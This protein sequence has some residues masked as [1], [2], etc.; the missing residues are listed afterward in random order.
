VV[1]AA[2]PTQRDRGVKR[3]VRANGMDTDV[4]DTI[5]LERTPDGL[6]VVIS[7]WIDAPPDRVWDLFTDTTRWPEWGP[8]VTAVECETRYIEAGSTG[9]VRT[10]GGRWL[11][12]AITRFGDRQWTWRIGQVGATGHRVRPTE[13]GCRVGFEV[14]LWAAPY[15]LVCWVALGRIESLATGEPAR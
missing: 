8:T 6:R 10:I 12:F 3:R 4:T 9:R 7:R 11:P 1:H 2:A 15:V 13:S 14:P 5:A